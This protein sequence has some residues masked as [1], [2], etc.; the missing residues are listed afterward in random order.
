VTNMTDTE[1]TLTYFAYGSNMLT[2]QLS[3][4][5]ALHA[6]ARYA[7]RPR[8]AV[9]QARQG[10]QRQGRCLS[11][12]PVAD[13]ASRRLPSAAFRKPRL[14]RAEGLGKGY[15]ERRCAF[16]CRAARR[17]RPSPMSRIPTLSKP[18]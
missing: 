7:R 2:S 8:I 11:Y 15:D 1:Q 18:T 9:S 16:A 3:D 17:S 14:D 4:A 12:G 13:A 10:R 6:A 5:P